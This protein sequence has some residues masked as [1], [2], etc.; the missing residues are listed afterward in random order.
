[1]EDVHRFGQTVLVPN[2]GGGANKG[3]G[4]V[5]YHDGPRGRGQAGAIRRCQQRGGQ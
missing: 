2:N 5:S 3:E 4:H 1:V